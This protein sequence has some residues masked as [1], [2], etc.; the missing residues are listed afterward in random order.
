MPTKRYKMRAGDIRPLATGR[1]ACFATDQITVDARRV[2]FMYR[3]PPDNPSDS[4][5]RFFSG[6]E[7][8]KYINNPDNTSV[9]DV[10]TIANYD[11]DI[12]PLIDAPVGSAFERDRQTGKFVAVSF[13]PPTD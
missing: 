2:C 10:N 12:I 9:F 6:F 8:D 7:G 11:R 5:W 1:G 13:R 3:E 4:G